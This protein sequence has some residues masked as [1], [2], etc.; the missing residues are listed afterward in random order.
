MATS[1]SEPGHHG[2]SCPC[3]GPPGPAAPLLSPCSGHT[4]AGHVPTALYPLVILGAGPSPFHHLLQCALVGAVP[5]PPPPEHDPACPSLSAFTPLGLSARDPSAPWSPVSGHG[6]LTWAGAGPSRSHGHTWAGACDH[7]DGRGSHGPHAQPRRG[8]R[9]WSPQEERPW[10]PPAR[11]GS[12]GED[13]TVRET[14]QAAGHR[15][16]PPR[17]DREGQGDTGTLCPDRAA[18]VPGPTQAL[19]GPG[20][21]SRPLFTAGRDSSLLP[22]PSCP[23][24][25]ELGRPGPGLVRPHVSSR[26]AVAFLG[27]MEEQAQEASP[28]LVS[29]LTTKPQGSEPCR[30]D[31]RTDVRTN[32]R[33]Q[34]RYK[35]S[36]IR[37]VT[38]C[39][40]P[41]LGEDGP[42]SRWQETDAGPSP[43]TTYRR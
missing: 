8:T 34:P 27:H 13:T 36:N 20:R 22:W 3:P 39:R 18:H 35:P 33:K 21:P 14:R 15:E 26:S 40:G 43:S 23:P 9:S 38:L 42:F 16:R 1:P 19:G 12:S 7:P 31:A 32:G 10:R 24:G 2:Q 4:P 11:R 25:E 41:S 5:I 37:S 17:P 6:H 29:E 30:A 28:G